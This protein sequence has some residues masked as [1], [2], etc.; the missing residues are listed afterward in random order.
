MS[1]DVNTKNPTRIR[2]KTLKDI[3]SQIHSSNA[4]LS[5]I[6]RKNTYQASLRNNEFD[7]LTIGKNG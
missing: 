6:E 1:F 4:D 2:I 7:E 5:K 3:N